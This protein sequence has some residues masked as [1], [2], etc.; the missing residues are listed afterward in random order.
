M[1]R[2]TFS[3]VLLPHYG[4][5]QYAGVVQAAYALNA[6]LRHAFLEPGEGVDGQAPAFVH[7]DDRNIVVEAVKKAE[8]DE[9]LIVR[10]YECHNSRGQAELVC[11]RKPKEAWLCD[12]EEKPVQELEV[13]D[14]VV[15][16]AYK[17]FEILTVK[18][19]V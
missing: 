18:L 16:F 9:G 15:P 14:G 19:I 11:A 12:L 6:P 1:G 4:P 17:P 8:D 7:V 10:L 2:H 3:Y 13:V 5:L